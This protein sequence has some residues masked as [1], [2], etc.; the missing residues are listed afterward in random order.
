MVQEPRENKHTPSHWGPLSPF[1]RDMA[2]FYKIVYIFVL[3]IR[4][5]RGKLQQR[6][7]QAVLN[8]KGHSQPQN[9]FNCQENEDT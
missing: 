8:L 4:P 5:D 6:D 2:L 7:K 9:Q 3:Q 1:L